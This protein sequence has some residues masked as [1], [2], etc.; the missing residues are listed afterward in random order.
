[1]ANSADLRRES[2]KGHARRMDM[3]FFDQDEFG[4]IQLLRSFDLFRKGGDRKI[5]NIMFE[6]KMSKRSYVFDY[7]YTVSRNKKRVRKR[8]TVMFINSKNLGLPEFSMKPENLWHRL[9]E[10]LWINRDIDFDSHTEFSEKYFLESEDEALLRYLF[11]KQVLDFFTLEK[12]WYLEGSNYYLII[13]SLNER[14]HPKVIESFVDM[15]NKLYELLK[16]NPDA[17]KLEHPL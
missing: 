12:N 16:T 15:G 14:F 10:W 6:E 3:K 13:Y 2:M 4:L 9:T 11:D 7:T 8:Q 1:M 17:I 5:D